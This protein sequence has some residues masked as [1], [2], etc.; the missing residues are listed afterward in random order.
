MVHVER[1]GSMLAPG[2]GELGMILRKRGS[3]GGDQHVLVRR[4]P[5]TG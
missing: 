4:L 5:R 1:S 2:M 3:L